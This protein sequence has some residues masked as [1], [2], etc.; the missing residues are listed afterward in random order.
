MTKKHLFAVAISAFLISNNSES[1]FANISS[2]AENTLDMTME[3][4]IQEYVDDNGA[5][6]AAVGLIDQGKIQFFTYYISGKYD[7]SDAYYSSWQYAYMES[8]SY[9]SK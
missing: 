4:L 9:G 6:G 7:F 8:A 1:L 3:T 2:K 5:V